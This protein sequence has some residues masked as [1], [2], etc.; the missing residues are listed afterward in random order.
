MSSANTFQGMARSI[1]ARNRSR[2]V[3]LRLPANSA[4]EKLNW[5]IGVFLIASHSTSYILTGSSDLFRVSLV[6]LYHPCRGMTGV[7]PLCEYLSNVLTHSVESD[8]GIKILG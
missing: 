1:S 4:S 2:R 3:T 7:A 8:I 5:L 6:Y